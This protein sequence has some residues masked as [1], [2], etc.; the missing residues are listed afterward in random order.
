MANVW[1]RRRQMRQ[2]LR[3][4]ASILSRPLGLS[5]IMLAL[6]IGG[7]MFLMTATVTSAVAAYSFFS[8]DLPS[9]ERLANREFAKS[10]FIYDRN[11]KLLYEIFDPRYGRR[12]YVTLPEISPYLVQATIATED[13]DF[14]SNNG[15]N[16]RG[17]ARA[18]AVMLRLSDDNDV[19]GGSSITQQLVKNVLIPEEERSQ[20][21]LSRKIKEMIM[22]GTLT[23]RYSKDQILEWY[24]NENNYGNLSYGI[25]TAARTYFA[26]TARDLTLA[27]ASMLAGV[28]QLPAV[29]SPLVS[30]ERAKERQ[31]QVLTLMVRHGYITESEA[32]DAYATEL[33]Y[34]A[35]R[36][37]CAAVCASPPASIWTC[38]TRCRNW[39]ASIS[40]PT[41]RASMRTTPRWCAL[42]PAPARCWRWWAALTTSRP[43]TKGRS[44]WRWP[45]ASLV[46]PSSRSPISTR[47]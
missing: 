20:R 45:N 24:L 46:L 7:A 21:L 33:V 23:Q 26:K 1:V 35:K 14:Y 40:R 28:P 27:E 10:T 6:A 12:H 44:T 13:A 25:E 42:I 19:Q 43:R 16:F 38:R 22:A 47:F 9:P 15:I 31:K 11:G 30:V 29:L 4:P 37:C 34:Q 8:R 5:L 18:A 41:A 36:R 17:I 2:R 32:N 3:R 39:R